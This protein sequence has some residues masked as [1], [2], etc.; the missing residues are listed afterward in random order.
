MYHAGIALVYKTKDFLTYELL[1]GIL[2]AVQGTGMWECVDFYPVS[3]EK[4][5]GLDTSESAGP[6]VKH[7]LKASMDDDRNDYYAIGTYEV[8]MNQW[9]PDDPEKDVEIGLR[10]DYD[11]YYALKTFYDPVKKRRV[12]WS[13]QFVGAE[14]GRDNDGDESMHDDEEEAASRVRGGDGGRA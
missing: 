3:T 2:H 8:G 5:K 7:M 1:P 6:T 11:K 13:W 14:G 12:L 10:Y 9:V 4:T